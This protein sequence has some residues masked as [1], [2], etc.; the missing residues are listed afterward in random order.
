MRT[1][2]FRLVGAVAVT[3]IAGGASACSGCGGDDDAFVRDVAPV[4]Q[5]RC[6]GAPCHGSLEGSEHELDPA[7]WLTFRIDSGGRITDMEE[8]RASVKAKVNSRDNPWFS[9]LLRKTL[10]VEEGG[11]HHYR[12][13]VFA[14]RSDPD[15]VTIA[16]WVQT[17]HDGTEG[18]ADP[19][20]TAN[21]QR[22][23]TDVYPFLI[24]RGCAT[25]TCHGSLMFGGAVFE[26]PAI[27][28]TLESP[29]ADLRKTYEEARRNL[30]LWGNPLRSR[31]LA[32]VLPLEKGGIPHKGGNDVFFAKEI[33]TGVDPRQAADVKKILGWLEVERAVE[34]GPDAAPWVEEPSIVFVGGPLPAAAPFAVQPYTPGTNL[35]RLDPP[36][37]GAPVNLTK[38]AATADIRDPAV[39]HDG[40]TIVFSMRTSQSDAHN[41]YTVGIDGKDLQQLTHDVAKGKSG[42]AVGNFA[43]AFGPNGGFSP[44][45]GSAPSERIYWSSTRAEDLADVAAV[46][47]ADLYAVDPDG[48]H[49]ERLTYTVVPEV[50]PTFLSA[51]EFRG[52][53]AYTIRRSVEGG[54][55]GVLFRF[56]V[57]HN[58]DFHIQPE[59][60]P[61][62]GMSE[63]PQVFYRLRE[64]P[65]GRA[66]L[67]LL[68]E[69]NVWR[70]GQLALLERQFAVEIPEGEEASA[71]LPGFR[72]ALTVLT[73][74]ASRSGASADGLWRD[75][76]ALP[77]GSIVVAHAEGP[78]DLDDSTSAP[79]TE[80]VRIVLTTK[81][82]ADASKDRP[83][84]ES[85]T[86]LFSDPSMAAS[87]P[88]AVYPRPAEDPPHPRA[89]SDDAPTATVVHSGVQ[90]IEAVLAQMQ[91]TGPRAVRD[92]LAFVRAVV[93]LSVAGPLDATP[94]PADETRD[95]FTSATKLSL[96]GN[97]PLFAAFE[98]PPASDGSLAAQIPPKVSVRIVTLDADHM[99]VGGLQHQWYATLPGERFPV[100]I[101]LASFNARCGGC[102]GA[103]DGQPS[104]V[105]EPPVDFIT[106]ASVTAALY[107][108][109][110]RRLPLELPTIDASFFVLVD[111]RTNVQPILAA[112]CATASCHAGAAPAGGLSLTSAA[113]QHYTDAYESLL[114]RGPGSANG[115]AYVDADGYRG[116]ASHLVERILGRDLDAPRAFDKPCPPQGSPQLTADEKVM[117]I[118]WI[119]LGAAFVGTP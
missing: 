35:Y 98:V 60:H 23:A 49:L 57:D 33:E 34:L 52:T 32:K 77:D 10:P 47:N 5:R 17:V 73:P 3:L 70:G 61:H 37:T 16:R 4:L 42:L 76:T 95:G 84:V 94:V 103:L 39:S 14:S 81:R 69:G 43:P 109:S 58:R 108:D 2:A 104:S 53:M 31:I 91:P 87:Q 107:K 75:P 97:M 112:K 118:R 29:R 65:E 82:G 24:N 40:K 48:N 114:A 86:T 106:Q 6:A 92:D 46:Q 119:E 85:A 11:L 36:Y 19:P 68:D 28:G 21:E 51:G 88:V 8:A 79:V 93:P 99:A 115:Y 117:L 12:G 9:T 101:P 15:F 71:T 55:K 116:R 44:A 74:D 96:T 80:L 13:A 66:T 64:L 38:A 83:A 102:H 7:R 89:W 41:L 63:P 90:V 59:A 45:D 22:F 113:T 110:D 25:A 50:T 54:Y 111:F 100:G 56:P 62:F 1:R 27:P 30:S 78:I 18:A 72:H 67:T 105:L 20:L 26:A